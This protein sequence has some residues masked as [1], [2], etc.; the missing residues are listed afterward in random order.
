VI[1]LTNWRIK[2]VTYGVNSYGVKQSKHVLQKRLFGVLWWYNPDNVDADLTGVYD[3]Y[4]EA[5]DEYNAK[6]FVVTSTYTTLGA[7]K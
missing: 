7:D 5:L 1:C 6:Q 3:T 4:Q 2:S